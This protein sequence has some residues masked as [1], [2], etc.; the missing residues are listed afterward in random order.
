MG[1]NLSRS[2][3]ILLALGTTPAVLLAQ[4]ETRVSGRVVNEASAPLPGVSVGIGA[5][6]VGAFTNPDG[7]YS[8]LIPPARVRGQQVALTVRLIGYSAQTRQITLAGGPI[9]ENFTLSANPLRLGE[10]IVTG[11]GMTT[12]REKLGN[13]INTVDSSLIARASEPGNIVSA[14]AGKAPNVEIRTQGGDPGSSASI[15]IRGYKSIQGTSQPLFVIDGVPIDN[16]TQSTVTINGNAGTVT[17][18]RAADINPND[19]ESVDILKGAAAAAIYGAR[20]ANGVILITTKSGRSGETRYSLRS[21]S[22]FE[23][24]DKLMPLQTTYAQGT[25][26]I[27]GTC[28]TADCSASQVAAFGGVIPAGQSF[29]HSSEIFHT[30]TQFDNNLM[31]SGGNERTT[32]YLSGGAL[33]QNGVIIGPNNSYVRNSMRLKGTHMLLSNVNIGGN[34]TYVDTH[35]SYVQKGSN[36]SG[37]LLGEYRSPPSFDNSQ[38][39]DP[40]SGLHRSYRFPNPTGNSL[41]TGR[42]YD[43]PYFTIYNDGNKS[44]LGRFIGNISADYTPTD[45]FTLKYTLGADYYND[46]RLETLPL[47]SS[48]A[49][50]GQVSRLDLNRLQVDHNLIATGKHSFGKNVDAALT[51]GQNLNSRRVRQVEMLGNDLIAPTPYSLQNTILWQP[52][53]TRSLAHIEGYLV[54]ASADLY[55]QIYLTAGV[56]NDGYSTFGASQRRHNYP[57]ASAAWKFTQLL[58]VDEAKGM[59]NYGKLRVAYGETGREPDLY[60][61][62]TALSQPTFGSGFNDAL[63]AGQSGSGGVTTGLLQGAGSTLRPERTKETEFGIDLGF[64]QQRADL[65]VTYYR[66]KSVDVLLNLPV[67]GAATGSTTAVRNGGQISNQGLELTLNVRPVTMQNFAW[68]FGVQWARNQNNVDTLAGAEFVGRT[69]GSFTGATGSVTRGYPVGAL[70]GP[71][72]AICGRGLVISNVNIDAGC[73]PEGVAAGALYIDANGLPVVDPVNRV[74]G[75]PNPKWTGSFSTSLKFGQNLRVSG[76]LDVRKGGDV[77]NGTKGALYRFGTHKDTE[78]RG[79][80]V[81]YGKDYFTDRYPVVAGPGANKGFVVGQ[82]WWEGQGGGFGT[83]GAQFVED[84]SFAKLREIGV[85]YTLQ[86]SFVR[87]MLSLTSMD[88]RVAGRN[89]HTWTKYSGQDPE[90]NLAG[91]EVLVQ[92]I[93]FFNTP[94]TRSFVFSVSLN[95]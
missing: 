88:L 74:I 50:K 29:D 30:G 77:W 81:T 21:E 42:G 54:Q 72:F 63:N 45:W 75:N 49:P 18:N 16:T 5:L 93:D 92:G 89:L 65:G 20:A 66:S 26:G 27:T 40:V 51:L 32:F 82:A 2:L 43:N 4:Q 59:L 67:S 28:T 33:H 85:T 24:V 47:T 70:R 36:T 31:V 46:Y 79:Q 55:E 9:A 52:T 7:R 84:G 83:V 1:R 23:K 38:Y 34:A 48:N 35:G 13:V 87:N 68:D 94:S 39:L 25:N 37:L 61:S 11:A 17:Q 90:A 73:G 60:S 41:R 19:V 95:R 91:A 22:M 62:I 3:H 56:R 10:V 6:G 78:L 71:D 64:L 15:R 58:G 44:E 86:N 80:T 8:F 57:K 12:T 53:E 76:L 14:L 69:L